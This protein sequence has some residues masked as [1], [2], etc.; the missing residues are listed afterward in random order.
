MTMNTSLSKRELQVLEM[1]LTEHT[2]KEIGFTLN[3]SVSRVNDIKRSIQNKWNVTTMVGLVKESIKRGYLKLEERVPENC[4]TC[5]DK[6]K[7]ADLFY[8]Y[9]YNE[10]GRHSII[11]S[12]TSKSSLFIHH[13]Q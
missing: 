7:Q 4:P 12:H 5:R 2:Q 9:D 3:L 10:I 8:M 13:N 1:L 11:C 6:V